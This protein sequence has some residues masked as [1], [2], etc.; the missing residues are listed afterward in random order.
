MARVHL[1]NGSDLRKHS[2][3][4]VSIKTTPRYFLQRNSAKNWTKKNSSDRS[5]RIPDSEN[6]HASDQAVSPDDY[7]TSKYH[8]WLTTENKQDLSFVAQASFNVSTG[9]K[10]RD[11]F[12]AGRNQSY[13][14]RPWF[15]YG[16]LEII[17]LP[18]TYPSWPDAN[19]ILLCEF[20][21]ASSGCSRRFL[22][23]LGFL[24]SLFP[25]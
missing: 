24:Y 16:N 17:N 18:P 15:R 23:G 12:R 2:T 7:H 11:R 6:C 19:N 8:N 25:T 5:S 22:V 20:L 21:E 13:H 14:S 1:K 4:K 3:Q 9:P 10:K